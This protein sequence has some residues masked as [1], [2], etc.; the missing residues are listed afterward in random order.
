MKMHC[1]GC[2]A[3]LAAAALALGIS[4]C[5]AQQ[6]PA[7]PIRMVVPFTPGSASDILARLLQPKLLEAWGQQ[8]IIDNRPS[9]GG[10]VA[11][12]IVAGAAPDGYTMMLTSSGFAGS[13]ALY[14]KLPY[15]SVKD[16]AGVTQVVSTPL[17]IVVAPTLG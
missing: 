3:A 17:V 13:A 7:G 8:I 16:F 4:D 15:D 14:E 1:S 2:A 5:T 12:T 6:Y 10:T 11:G 9:A